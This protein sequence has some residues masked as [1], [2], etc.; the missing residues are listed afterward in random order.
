[1]KF[2]SLNLVHDT[3]RFL[4]NG[5]APVRLR[6]IFKDRNIGKARWI[7]KYYGEHFYLTVKEYASLSAP[8]SDEL[9][10]IKKDL[11]AL[12]TKAQGIVEKDPDITIALFESRFFG[13]ATDTLTGMFEKRIADMKKA[14]RIGTAR[15]YRTALNTFKRF[16]MRA[17]IAKE[18][19]KDIIADII[20]RCELRFSEITAAWLTD[21]QAWMIKGSLSVNTVGIHLRTLRAVFNEAI[22]TSVVPADFYPFRAFK[23]RSESKFKIPLSEA[24]IQAL[25]DYAPKIEDRAEARDYFLFSYFCNGMNL[26]DVCRLRHSDITDE[27][28]VYDRS[29]TRATKIN[30]KKIIIPIDHETA[31]IIKRRG[32]SLDPGGYIFPILEENLSALTIKSRV[33]NFIRKINQALKGVATDLKIKKKLTTVIARHTFANRMSN[34][35]AERRMIQE[36]LGHQN[37]ETTEHYLG[38]MDVEKIKKAREAL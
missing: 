28:L 17:E 2:I 9:R 16:T 12:V 21:Y 22:S 23:I 27:F 30:F 15:T 19:D 38:T 36:A 11:A 24:E 31:A 20:E 10:V 3:R 35:G 18:T 37:S 34:S 32:R 7:H 33:Q 13:I 5:K 4:K 29:K 8:R 25:K 6:L 14:E 26:V 1:M